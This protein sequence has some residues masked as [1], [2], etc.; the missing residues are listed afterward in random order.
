MDSILNDF[1]ASLSGAGIE[2]AHAERMSLDAEQLLA[3]PSR[4]LWRLWWRVGRALLTAWA[5]P[6]RVWLMRARQRGDLRELDPHLLRDIGVLS[7]QAVRESEKF[8]WQE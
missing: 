3:R 5:A 1:S 4:E 6:L 2:R 7:G 8:F